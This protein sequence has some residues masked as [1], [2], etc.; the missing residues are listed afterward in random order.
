MATHT[1]VITIDGPSGSGKG[2]ISRLLAEKLGWHLLDSGA[3][4]RVLALAAL[5]HD[6]SA[7]DEESL[8]ALAANLDVKFEAEEDDGITHIILEGEDVT[9]T[10]RTEQVGNMASKIAALPRVREALLRR[11]RGFKELPGL[12]ADGRDMG[13]VVFTDADAK[14]FLTASAEERAQRRYKQLLEKGFDANIDQ[15]ITE[16]EERDERDTNRSVAPL[17]PADDALYVDSTDLSI[18][19]VLEEILT[20]AHSKL[21]KD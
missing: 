11:Q 16:I 2:T 3:I 17:K 6:F 5:H 18:D 12:V 15:L 19:Q 20:F 21:S 13:T 1:P 4:Y 7:D 9:L 8:V 14:V 10:I